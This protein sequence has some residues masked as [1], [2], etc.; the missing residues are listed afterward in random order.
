MCLNNTVAK[1]EDPNDPSFDGSFG[2][3]ITKDPHE[4][5]V[6]GVNPGT[7]SI[8]VVVLTLLSGF[9]V[10]LVTLDVHVRPVF[11]PGVRSQPPAER[12]LVRGAGQSQQP[13]PEEPAAT[14]VHR[15]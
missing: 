1:L 12:S 13:G 2:A 4:F 5:R 15:E 3:F 6:R 14:A 9:P 10:G 8:D 7:T 11:H